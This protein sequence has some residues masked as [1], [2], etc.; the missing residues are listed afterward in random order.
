MNMNMRMEV[1]S[2]NK[3]RL[4]N[5]RRGNTKQTTTHNKEEDGHFVRVSHVSILTGLSVK[6]NL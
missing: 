1:K 5:G 4:K 2:K 6:I 3:E